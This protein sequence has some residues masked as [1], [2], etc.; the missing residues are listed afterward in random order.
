MLVT[1]TTRNYVVSTVNPTNAIKNKIICI[2]SH[3]THRIATE[4]QGQNIEY[5]RT[6]RTRRIHVGH[7]VTI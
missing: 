6:R 4:Q 7:G 1:Q 5:I 2:L 3:R